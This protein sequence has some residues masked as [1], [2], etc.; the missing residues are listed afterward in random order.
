MCDDHV[1]IILIETLGEE[2][3]KFDGYYANLL[4]VRKFNRRVG[5]PFSGY[6]NIAQTLGESGKEGNDNNHFDGPS[7]IIKIN[8]F[9]FVSDFRNRRIQVYSRKKLYFT[10]M[11]CAS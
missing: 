1:K 11:I 8:G 3:W 9:V 10:L 7:D 2:R 6:F 5:I 4:R